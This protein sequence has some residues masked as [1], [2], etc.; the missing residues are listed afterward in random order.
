M[1]DGPTQPIASAVTRIELAQAGSPGM[2]LGSEAALLLGWLATRL[3]WKARASAGK[4]CLFRPDGGEVLVV[5]RADAVPTARRG[6]LV[7]VQI[8]ASGRELA[9]RGALARETGEPDSATWHLEVRSRGETQRIDQHV[10]LRGSGQAR[11][12]ERTLHRPL[13]D[14]ALTESVDWV[15][16]LGTGALAC[17]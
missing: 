10:R 13:H 17:A 12:L 2:N 8:D 14:D 15:A 11:L 7:S 16:A 5:L 1:F 3:E 9:M 6:A 4:L